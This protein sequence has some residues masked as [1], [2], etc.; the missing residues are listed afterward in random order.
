M[1]SELG[2]KG[3]SDG[4][5]SRQCMKIFFPLSLL[6]DDAQRK[7]KSVCRLGGTEGTKMPNGDSNPD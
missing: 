2:E 7:K 1:K 5:E 4:Q 3:L 6:N